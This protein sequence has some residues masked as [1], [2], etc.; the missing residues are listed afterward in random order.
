MATPNSTRLAQY[1]VQY[2]LSGIHD[3]T[4]VATEAAPGTT[5]RL[6]RFG[7]PRFYLKVDDGLTTNWIDISSPATGINLGTGSQV[8]KNVVGNQFQFRTLKGAGGVVVTQLANEISISFSGASTLNNLSC[9]PSVVVGDLCVYSGALLVKPASNLNAV[10]PY[11][12]VGIAYNKPTLNT[13]DLLLSGQVSGLFGLTQGSP[14]FI[15]GTGDFTHTNPAT[16]NV[17]MLGFAISTTEIA[18]NIYQ[19]FRRI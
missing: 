17:Q 19:I 6:L 13:V 3:P 4:L 11:G 5:Y 1:T 14:L 18:F 16:G 2:D 9:D 8:L 12:I 15:S 7:M 10:I